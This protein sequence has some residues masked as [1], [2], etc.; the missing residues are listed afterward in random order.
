MDD[1]LPSKTQRKKAMHALQELGAELVALNDERLAS[2]AL[3]E[4]LYEAVVAAKNLRGFE[5]RRRQM[6]YIGKLMRSL[7]PE[8]I[9]ARLEAWKAPAREHAA[10]LRLMEQWRERLLS[11]SSALNEFLAAYPDADAQRLRALVRDTQH[12]Q[13]TNAPRKSYRA[14]F[15]LLREV[16]AQKSQ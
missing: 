1:E 9:R 8:P 5:A 10:Q 3:P 2:I 14:L 12:E 11:E 7:D 15:R 6:Q 4:R 13:A 16:L